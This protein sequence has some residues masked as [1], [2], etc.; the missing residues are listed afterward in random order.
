VLVIW[1]D[2]RCLDQD[3]GSASIAMDVTVWS[4]HDNSCVHAWRTGKTAYR[5]GLEPLLIHLWLVILS[6]IKVSDRCG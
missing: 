4:P 5:K 2:R 1:A 3:V 6:A